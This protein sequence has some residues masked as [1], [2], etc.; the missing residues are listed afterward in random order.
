MNQ[1]FETRDLSSLSTISRQK[2]TAFTLDAISKRYVDMSER[3]VT[4]QRGKLSR[5]KVPGHLQEEGEVLFP[6]VIVSYS[7]CQVLRTYTRTG[8]EGARSN[9]SWL[10]SRQF[11]FSAPYGARPHA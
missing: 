9:R 1:N 4:H 7:I 3:D 5:T 11:S 2:F 8:S 10:E 6:V